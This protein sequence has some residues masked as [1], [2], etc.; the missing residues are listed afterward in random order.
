MK[1]I[2]WGA[3]YQEATDKLTEIITDYVKTY[4]EEII[5]KVSCNKNHYYVFFT[6]GDNWKAVRAHESQRGNRCNISYVSKN[7]TDDFLIDVIA[8][9]TT[10]LPFHAIMKY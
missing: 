6:N 9:S 4:G 1:G 10:S 2:V 8:H 7:I 5:D 3:T